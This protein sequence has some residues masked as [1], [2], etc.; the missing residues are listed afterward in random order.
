MRKALADPVVMAIM[1]S[2]LVIS[3][4][5]YYLFP[6]MVLEWTGEFGWSLGHVMGAFSVALALQG[7][8]SWRVGR[9]IDR[10]LGPAVMAMGAL[11]CVL[12]LLLLTRATTLWQFYAIWAGLGIAMG[13]TLYDAVFALLIRSR[14][15]AAKDAIAAIT[16]VSGLAS[17]A[18]FVEMAILGE[19]L[20]WRGILWL[21]A[22]C[23]F[24]INLPLIV[25]AA[26]Q[27]ERVQTQPQNRTA[28]PADHPLKKRSYWA[29]TAAISLSALGLGMIVSH[30]LPMMNWLGAEARTA[31]FAA[32][33]IGPA[34]FAGRF[35]L[36]MSRR[37]WNQQ[38]L[39]AA[40]LLGLAIA[41]CFLLI[42]SLGV[43]W[44]FAFAIMHGACYGISSIMRPLIIREALGHAG[45]G[46]SQ[47]A[48]LAP[49]FMAFVAAP[50][51]AAL[52]ADA[53]GYLS[54]LVV[55]I[56]AQTLGAIFLG[57]LTQMTP[58]QA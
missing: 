56:L 22:G 17:S 28:P 2:Q 39:A 3:T 1:I 41:P 12:G 57:R 48:V 44:L 55:C 26:R 7:L 6:A 35:W 14:D 43:A 54:V 19:T 20:G 24:F 38:T 52:L 30:L 34:Q 33:L 13:M 40:C 25:F 21:F 9:W 51:L 31:Y 50:F 49:A 8:T 16:L 58:R 29:L 5:L 45:F 27:L 11:A 18:A 32:A 4:A 37:T 23:V 42:S 15:H 46:R 10:G 47:G 36:A 53:H